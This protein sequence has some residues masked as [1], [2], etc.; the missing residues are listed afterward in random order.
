MEK[1]F[2]V[3]RHGETDLNSKQIWQGTTANPDLNENGRLQAAKLGEKLLECG[4]EKIYTSPVLRAMNTT[5]IVNQYL[6]AP[7]EIISDLHE[8]C[9]G[10]AE[11]KT[12][13][14][15]QKIWPQLM[16]DVLHPTPT[17]WD[18]KYPGADSES[19]HQVFE[20]VSK[21]LLHIART[22]SCQNLGISTHG[23]VMSALLSGLQSYGVAVPNCCVAQVK[24]DVK[25]DKLYFVRM[26]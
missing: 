19:K 22:T 8:C 14:E 2:Y 20:R 17:T 13:T 26:L 18:V 24:Y 5:A 12:M 6:K 15:T 25:T 21:V 1:T 10:D 9:F 4:I 23:G 7:V 11:G 16:Y 3:F